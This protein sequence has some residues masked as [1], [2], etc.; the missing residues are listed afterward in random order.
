MF[1]AVSLAAF[2]F[3]DEGPNHFV[4]SANDLLT[5][6]AIIRT[7]CEIPE[8]LDLIHAYTLESAEADPTNTWTDEDKTLPKMVE[9]MQEV[10]DSCEHIANCHEASIAEALLNITSIRI[11]ESEPPAQ[12]PN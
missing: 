4:E 1:D 11:V 5:A 7:V 9:A 2:L 6:A 12:T 8:A 3:G 10:A